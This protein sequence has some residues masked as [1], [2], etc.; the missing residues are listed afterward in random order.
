MRVLVGVKRAV[1]YAVKVRVAADKTGIDLANVK[2]SM[3]P[4]CEIALEEAIRM[5]EKKKAKEVIAISIG[6]KA[7]QETLRTAL[8]M[9]ADK[10]IH[11]TTDMRTDQVLQPL[12]VSK[13]IAKYA[14][15]NECDLV[16]VGKQAIDGD[17]AQTGPMVAGA[18]GWSQGTFAAGLDFND[19]GLEI[20]RETDSGTEKLQLKLPAVITADL[21]LNQP[22]YTTLPNIMKAKKKPIETAEAS[23]L[24]IDLEP[25]N[26]V[27]S[28]SEPP[29]RKAG[30][31]VETVDDLLQKLKS[32]GSI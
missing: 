16:V 29:T 25:R 8:A 6:P 30:I 23:S 9:G 2:M 21:R 1:D 11:I 15:D 22:R 17:N 7:S 10:G 18:L 24:G 31:V 26:T 13:I 19:N 27:T 5:K 12:A 20:E 14:K 3:N 4:F 32:D 28:V